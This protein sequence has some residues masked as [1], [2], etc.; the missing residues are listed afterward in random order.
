MIQGSPR[1]RGQGSISP[2]IRGGRTLRKREGGRGAVRYLGCVLAFLHPAQAPECMCAYATEFEVKCR[3]VLGFSPIGTPRAT[4]TWYNSGRNLV[5]QRQSWLWLL[6]ESLASN[7]GR[8][9]LDVLSCPA[10][11]E[12]GWWSHQECSCSRGKGILKPKA[13]EWT[14]W[15]G[16]QSPISGGTLKVKSRSRCC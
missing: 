12:E 8:R 10:Q 3:G 5:R 1:Q 2:F 13:T 4:T 15:P 6:R 7:V 11:G 14:T 16:N 9:H